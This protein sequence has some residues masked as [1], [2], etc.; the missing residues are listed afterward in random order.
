MSDT[1]RNLAQGTPLNPAQIDTQIQMLKEQTPASKLPGIKGQWLRVGDR[2]PSH[3]YADLC[4][5][6]EVCS[7]G[8]Y[9]MSVDDV[10]DEENPLMLWRPDSGSDDRPFLQESRVLT[11]DN[12]IWAHKS[13]IVHRAVQ[14]GCTEMQ[15]IEILLEDR[16]RLVAELTRQLSMSPPI[17]YLHQD[18]NANPN[19]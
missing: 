4:G 6:V 18:F 9:D 16:E 14:A 5:M 3:E 13:P 8:F 11:F 12:Q 10:L 1:L 2:P 7:D 15:L 19:L 17:T